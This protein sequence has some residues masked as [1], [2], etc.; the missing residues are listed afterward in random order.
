MRV[1]LIMGDPGTPAAQA[2][3]ARLGHPPLFAAL[4]EA[5][6]GDPALDP[7]LDAFLAEL[8]VAV[9]TGLPGWHFRVAQ[10]AARRG[11]HL[12]LDGPPAPSVQEAEAL[13]A[14]AEEAGIEIG[15]SRPWRYHPALLAPARSW[16]AALVT[17][18]ASLGR[19][20]AWPALLTDALD[21]GC[22]LVQ[23]RS[24]LRIDAEAVRASRARLAA[25]AFS[26]RFH[27]GAF[28]QMSLAP[29]HPA[30]SYR[31]FAAGADVH[32]SADLCRAGGTLHDPGAAPLRPLRPLPRLGR[33]A[34]AGA[35]QADFLRALARRLPAPTSVLDALHTMRLTERLMARLR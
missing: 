34:L 8:D 33:G 16:R 5:L 14:L 7:P 31:L 6:P 27:N 29:G 30:P 24:V 25:V 3:Q 4:A 21:L 12:L 2:L 10:N 35:A 17:F 20:P 18:Y 11:V 23:S 13:V 19:A 1:G 32:L 15:V 22:T 9:V 26:I 28:V